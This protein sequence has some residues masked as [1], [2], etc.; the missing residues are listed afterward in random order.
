MKD[1]LPGLSWSL[2]C[3]HSTALE[4]LYCDAQESVEEAT[5][6]EEDN[7]DAAHELTKAYGSDKVGP[8]LY[9]LPGLH[10][11]HHRTG[12]VQSRH[13]SISPGRGPGP[14][15][16]REPHRHTQPA[17]TDKLPRLQSSRP[18]CTSQTAV[19]TTSSHPASIHGQTGQTPVVEA[20]LHISDSGRT[21][22]SISNY[23]DAS[24]SLTSTPAMIF[25]RV[26]VD[27]EDQTQACTASNGNRSSKNTIWAPERPSALPD[28]S[29]S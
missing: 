27:D 20:V 25:P 13:L 10:C 5:G 16:G 12:R 29:G 22:A 21:A 2:H 15:S 1:T 7:D 8:T 6:K 19:G 3:Q 9:L 4:E 23:Y 11:P 14:Q 17:S 26:A 28:A 18:S 24:I